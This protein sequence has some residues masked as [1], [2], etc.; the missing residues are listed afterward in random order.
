MEDKPL[1]QEIALENFLSFGEEQRIALEP[2]NVLIGPNG[3]G[4]SNFLEA[5]A[6]LHAAPVDLPKP[7][8]E[9]GGAIEWL[10]KGGEEPRPAKVAAVVSYEH[11]QRLQYS[12]SFRAEAGRFVLEDETVERPRPPSI[13]GEAYFRYGYQQGDAAVVYPTMFKEVDGERMPAPQLLK[14]GGLKGDQ[15]VLAQRKDPEQY[16]E[17]AHLVQILSGI[18]LYRGFDLDAYGVLK[19]PQKV[20][21]IKIPLLE[22]GSNLALVFNDLDNR[23]AEHRLVAELQRFCPTIERITQ[24]IEG[25]TVQVLVHEKGFRD[26]IPASRLSDGILRYLCLLAILCHP[27]PPPLVCIDEP[28]QGMHPDAIHR[29]GELLIEASQRTQLVV[30]THSDRLVSALR[31]VP[32]SVV[33][34]ERGEEGTRLE[35]LEPDRLQQWLEEYTLGEL[36]M[37]GHLGGTRW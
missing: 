16:P 35:R 9:S 14:L 20:D 1:I 15:S 36:W 28:E 31:D 5:F 17:F 7:I 29:I 12:V 10:W 8:R 19:N 32:E 33:V 2:L 34:C 23:G 4:K 25:R 22:S 27:E 11:A 37:Q 24:S 18:E 3:S 26:P 6:L 21:S 30:T 13:G